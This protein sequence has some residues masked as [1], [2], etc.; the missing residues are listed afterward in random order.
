LDDRDQTESVITIDRNSQLGL[1]AVDDD[2]LYA[3]LDWLHE[4]HPHVRARSPAI[5]SALAKRH[6]QNDTL[7]LLYDASSSYR[8]GGCCPLAKRGY[9]RDGKK[10]SLQIVVTRR[11]AFA[12]RPA[13]RA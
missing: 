11:R 2:E 9:S 6:L 3:A 10:G 1:G 4:R 8:E 12:R 7:V 5:E 13:L